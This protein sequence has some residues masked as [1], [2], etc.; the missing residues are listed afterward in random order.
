MG[1]H[2][3]FESDF[4]C[5]TEYMSNEFEN[6]LK[7]HPALS[8]TAGKRIKCVLTGHEMVPKLE[9]VQHH[10]NGKKFLRLAKEWSVPTKEELEYK[11]NTNF[12]QEHKKK[13]NMLYC[14]LTGR[15][16]KNETIHLQRHLRGRKFKKALE[17]WKECEKNGST[18]RPMRMWGSVTDNEFYQER[19]EDIHDSD[20]DENDLSDLHPWKNKLQNTK[21]EE[22]RMEEENR[23]E[24]ESDGEEIEE[25]KEKKYSKTPGPKKKAEKKKKKKKKK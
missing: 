19:L 18:F 20:E 2:P 10:I 11:Q 6:I 17:H 8:L 5:L 25:K 14:K 12:L 4:D 21:D 15:S 9:V 3:I 13:S 7:L 22:E 16:I 1:T 24:N 23:E